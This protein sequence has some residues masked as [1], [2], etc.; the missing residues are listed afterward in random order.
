MPVTSPRAQLRSFRSVPIEWG[1]ANLKLLAKAVIQAQERLIMHP[2]NVASV[3]ANYT[4]TEND[5]VV[6][7]DATTG[8]ITVTLPSTHGREGRRLIVKKTD[9]SGNAVTIDGNGA[10]TID[11]ATTVALSTQ[12]A[13]REMVSDLSNWHVVSSI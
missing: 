11:G 8:A 1:D 6:L 13:T 7:A 9:S 3:T 12:Y 2:L 4:A 10:E 5:L